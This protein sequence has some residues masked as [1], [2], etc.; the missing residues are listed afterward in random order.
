SFFM[1]KFTDEEKLAVV[2]RYK[3]GMESYSTIGKSIGTS[4]SVVR[5]WVMQYERNGV[6][7]LLKKSYTNYSAQFK[8]DVLNFMNDNGTSPNETATL[9]HITSPALIRKWRIQFES[10]GVDALKS[11]KKGRPTMKKDSKK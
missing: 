9:F 5:N 11:K 7:G 4:D 3:T 2:Q 6:E 1:V 10:Q 8:L